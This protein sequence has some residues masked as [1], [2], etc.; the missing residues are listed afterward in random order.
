MRARF[1][2]AELIEVDSHWRIPGLFGDEGHPRAED[3]LWTPH[4]Q[5]AKA[6]RAAVKTFDIGGLQGPNGS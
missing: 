1:P 5:E 2:H 4:N 3:L 6:R